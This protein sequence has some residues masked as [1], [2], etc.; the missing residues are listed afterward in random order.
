M[1]KT[2]RHRKAIQAGNKKITIKNF[3]I[4]KNGI[5]RGNSFLKVLS[6]L[7]NSFRKMR[8]TRQAFSAL[9][10]VGLLSIASCQKDIVTPDAASD[11]TLNKASKNTSV[12][13]VIS[14]SQS[15]RYSQT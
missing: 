4:Q 2:G 9:L 6:F 1:K 12:P 5:N 8:T 15:R 10:T 11:M 13:G 7:K 14:P 3:T